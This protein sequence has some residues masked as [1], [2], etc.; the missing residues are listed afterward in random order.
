MMT[1]TLKLIP[2]PYGKKLPTSTNAA[3]NWEM[4]YRDTGKRD[5]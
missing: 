1:S 4:R 5:A 2:K 3:R